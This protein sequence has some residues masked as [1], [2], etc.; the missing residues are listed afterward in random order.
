MSQRWNFVVF[1]W[2]DINTVR[3]EKG[4]HTC[5]QTEGKT[6]FQVNDEPFFPRLTRSFIQ[7][8]PSTFERFS[9]YHLSHM[10]IYQKNT[11]VFSLF[12]LFLYFP[13]LMML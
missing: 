2:N 4:I 7:R 3:R 1:F 8:F 5:S 9:K 11:N 12:S 13:T 6:H 10:S